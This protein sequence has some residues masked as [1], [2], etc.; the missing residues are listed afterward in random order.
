MTSKENTL[1]VAPCGMNCGICMA[2][3]RKKNKCSGCRGSDEDKT[4]TRLKCGIKN[5]IKSNSD[6][7]YSCTEYP[8]KAIKHIDKRYRTRYG[9]SMIENLDSIRKIGISAFLRNEK[10]KWSCPGCK[11]TICVHKGCCMECGRERK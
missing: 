2:F 6:F 11:G 10:R 1:L 5:C 7:C 8:C 4:I 9:M 3:L